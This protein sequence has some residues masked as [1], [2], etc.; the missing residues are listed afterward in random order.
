MLRAD[1]SRFSVAIGDPFGPRE[2]AG[3]AW[4]RTPG[5]GLRSTFSPTTKMASQNCSSTWR[6]C[7][8]T[9]RKESFIS[10]GPKNCVKKTET[11]IYVIKEHQDVF[12]ICK[13]EFKEPRQEF[14]IPTSRLP[15]CGRGREKALLNVLKA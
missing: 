9:K 1:R 13:N 11:Q 10:I 6:R 4:P 15:A 14:A 12:S 8:N 3:R 2:V 7:R 5:W